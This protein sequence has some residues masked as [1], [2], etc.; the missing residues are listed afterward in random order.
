VLVRVLASAAILVQLLS[1]CIDHQV[2]YEQR[3]VRAHFWL[4]NSLM[5]TDSP[6]LSRPREIWQALH[7][8]G[9]RPGMK[10]V[11]GAYDEAPAPPVAASSADW[12]AA[13]ERQ[14]LPARVVTTG[15][16]RLTSAE[17]KARPRWMDE[18]YVLNAPRPW[19]LWSL[20]LPAEL[21]PAPVL[22]WLGLGLLGLLL[23]LR[24]LRSRAAPAP[25]GTRLPA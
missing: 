16:G 24:R 20:G 15:S 10:L 3:S 22:P 25:V 14:L 1:L 8:E 23:S 11:P 21:R 12:A 9:Y 2:Y 7:F 19:L 13:Y 5:Y 6:L 18:Y 4:D 17:R